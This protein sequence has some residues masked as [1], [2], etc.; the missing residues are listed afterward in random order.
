MPRTISTKPGYS[1]RFWE[2][3]EMTAP[4]RDA[5]D[6]LRKAADFRYESDLPQGESRIFHSDMRKLS[7]YRSSFPGRIRCVITS[8]PYM[9]VTSFEEDQWLRL[10][11]LGGPTHPRKG[12]VSRDDR[13][14]GGAAY[15]RFIAEFWRMLSELLE[16]PTDIVIRLGDRENNPERL[17][18][19][20][21]A[22]SKFYSRPIALV[23]GFAT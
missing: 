13:H 10:W 8:P 11:F 6:V 18:Q 16:G 2:E 14:G 5:F 7:R 4:K 19:M 1:V 15:W 21:V 9:D 12:S 23:E 22:S 17:I 3:R 20:L